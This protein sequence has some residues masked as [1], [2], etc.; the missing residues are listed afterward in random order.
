MTTF[1]KEQLAEIASWNTAQPLPSL[2]AFALSLMERAETAEAEIVNHKS[3]L[4]TQ[5]AATY[6]AEAE[7]DEAAA[8]ATVLAHAYTTDSRPP[9]NIVDRS[10]QRGKD[11]LD[12]RWA[13]E[14]E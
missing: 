11:A 9:Q 14:N 12:R 7:R 10:I 2:A 6:A 3:W 8:D 4:T 5:Q 13:K 1:T